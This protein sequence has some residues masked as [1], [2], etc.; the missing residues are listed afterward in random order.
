M[1]T[2]GLRVSLCRLRLKLPSLIL[3]LEDGV[4]K[5]GSAADASRPSGLA[6]AGELAEPRQVA[7]ELR[8]LL[9]PLSELAVVQQDYDEAAP[10]DRG[11]EAR[12]KP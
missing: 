6:A 12:E 7:A 4:G 10:L 3:A 8:P 11:D 9:P 2:E 1:R 5:P